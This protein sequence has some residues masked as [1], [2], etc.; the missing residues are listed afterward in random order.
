MRISLRLTAQ[1]GIGA[2][3]CSAFAMAQADRFAGRWV[4]PEAD[5]GVFVAVDIGE[6]NTFTL[7]GKHLDG[8]AEPLT[9]P[10]LNLTRVG[11]RAT[12]Q[13]TLPD[14]ERTT[15]DLEMR[16]A[17]AD[18]SAAVRVTRPLDPSGDALPLWNLRRAR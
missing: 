8:T 1:F 17:A 11:D 2:V 3:L 13:V 5:N 4:A 10:I 6:S 18:D 7:P 14:E 15:L 12:F 16:V 9:L